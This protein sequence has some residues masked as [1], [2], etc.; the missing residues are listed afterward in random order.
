MA[1]QLN[2]NKGMRAGS[3]TTHPTKPGSLRFSVPGLPH[4]AFFWESYSDELP[5][6]LI[7]HDREMITWTQSLCPFPSAF[8][9]L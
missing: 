8:I 6:K 5:L 3:E 9:G 1:K 2:N 7:C 4:S